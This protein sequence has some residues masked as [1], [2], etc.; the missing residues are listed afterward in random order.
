RALSNRAASSAKAK[1]GGKR[2]N[3][4]AAASPPS[5]TGTQPLLYAHS[6]SIAVSPTSHTASPGAMPLGASARSTTAQCGLSKAASPAPTTAPKRAD[7]PRH[8][9]GAAGQQRQALEVDDAEAVEIDALRL[10]PALAEDRRKRLAQ[11][12]A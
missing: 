10:L 4:A 8:Q 11:A 1:R 2:E 9:L 7:Q 3:S 12:E 5:S 6:M